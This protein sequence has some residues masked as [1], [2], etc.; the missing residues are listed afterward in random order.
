VAQSTEVA[1]VVEV[2]E[3]LELEEEDVDAVKIK[4]L[5]KTFQQ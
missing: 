2:Q 1:P 5:L 3:V 4:S